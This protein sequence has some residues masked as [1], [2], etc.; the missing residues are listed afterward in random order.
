LPLEEGSFFLCLLFSE[1][2]IL[3]SSLL[4]FLLMDR[5][6]FFDSQH[7]N[8]L[9]LNMTLMVINDSGNFPFNF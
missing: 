3:G 6:L 4:L 1:N 8:C 2:G 9:S 7:L 5:D